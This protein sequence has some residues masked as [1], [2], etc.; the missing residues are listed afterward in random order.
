MSTVLDELSNTI[1]LGNFLDSQMVFLFIKNCATTLCLPLC[2]IFDSSIKNGQIPEQWRNT[3]VVPVHKKGVTS[4]PNNFRPI[5]LTCTS[6]R[7]ME[8]IINENI[9]S[10]LLHNHLLTPQQK[11]INLLQFIRTS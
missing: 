5:S 10:Y 3:I 9:L 4:N 1:L 8:R 11:K 7:V 6:C 2:H